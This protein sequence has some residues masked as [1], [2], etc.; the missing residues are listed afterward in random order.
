MVLRAFSELCVYSKFGHHPHPLG[1]LCAKFRLYRSLHRWRKIAY[2]ITQSPSC[3]AP[4]TEAY[5]SENE[6]QVT[7]WHRALLS[8]RWG[9]RHTKWAT[10]SLCVWGWCCYF[11]AHDYSETKDARSW[12]MAARLVRW[13]LPLYLFHLKKIDSKWAKRWNNISKHP[14]TRRITR[15]QESNN[16]GGLKG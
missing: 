7:Q 8:R 5:A 3:G 11:S 1:Y 2:S 4:G 6:C 15:C 13:W 10:F 14:L 16:G 12:K 9:S